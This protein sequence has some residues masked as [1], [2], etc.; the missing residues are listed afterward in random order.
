MARF[1]NITE[2]ISALKKREKAIL[3]KQREISFN[4]AKAIITDKAER[5]FVNGKNAENRLIGKYSTRPITV[6]QKQSP[7]S[8]G[9]PSRK[10]KGGYKSFKEFIG[11]GPKVN[12]RVF[13]NLERDYITSLRWIGDRWVEQP[14]RPENQE[15]LRN[16]LDPK[17]YGNV[18]EFTNEE[19]KK[20][21]Q[22]YKDVLTRIM[23]GGK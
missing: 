1:D 3:D 7:K 13:G 19:N 4:V 5:V 12:L 8:L 16:L 23:K 6:D 14:K 21:K 10:F 2:Y 11:R 22:L 9:G 15:K 18:F 17:K 20:G